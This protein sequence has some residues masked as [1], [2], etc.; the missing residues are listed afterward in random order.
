MLALL[1]IPYS[2]QYAVA[3]QIFFSAI[4]ILLLTKTVAAVLSF[5]LI[6]GQYLIVVLVLHWVN[7]A[8]LHK[9]SYFHVLL[10]WYTISVLLSHKLYL[11][12]Y[13]GSW[14][15]MS[16][17]SNRDSCIHIRLHSKCFN[18]EQKC[19]SVFS[20]SSTVCVVCRTHTHIWPSIL[21]FTFR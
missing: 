6:A 8:R 12:K 17:H 15:K 9:D 10:L 11:H 14:C 16:N 19:L 1:L 18:S 21:R 3:F 4:D 5:K 13:V 2:L 7:E 20:F